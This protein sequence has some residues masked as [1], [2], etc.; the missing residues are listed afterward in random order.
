MRV[1]AIKD[2]TYGGYFRV[3]PIIGE[4]GSFPGEVFEID[5]RPFPILDID[6]KPIFELNED[7]KSIIGKDGKP[8]MK[9][10]VWFS[11]EW[12]VRVSDDEPITNDYPKFEIPIQ[13]RERKI[14]PNQPK[15][16]GV[17]QTPSS[18]I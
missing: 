4:Q 17:T 9:M 10:G 8:K 16:G 1:R 2:G 14:N 13:Y 6:G 18:V 12:M 11:P 5:N 7:K 15:S 3:G